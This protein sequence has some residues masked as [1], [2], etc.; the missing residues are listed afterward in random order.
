MLSRVPLE[1]EFRVVVRCLQEGR[2]RCQE[3]RRVPLEQEFRVG[4]RCQEC[5]VVVLPSVECR[6]QPWPPPSHR[7]VRA[8]SPRQLQCQEG[9][10]ALVLS[11][12]GW[13][14]CPLPPELARGAEA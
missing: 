4:R 6:V 9:V 11:Q 10:W 12:E 2:V 3:F 1:E 8:L 5:R 7:E 14:H 13:Q